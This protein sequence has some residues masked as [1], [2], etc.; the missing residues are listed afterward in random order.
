MSSQREETKT[1]PSAEGPNEV[2]ASGEDKTTGTPKKKSVAWE[3]ELVKKLDVTWGDA[4]SILQIARDE[5]GINQQADPEESKEEI[6]AKCEEVA[7]SF[8]KTPRVSL[9]MQP[10]RSNEKQAETWEVEI[11]DKYKCSLIDA[12]SMLQMAKHELEIEEKAYPEEKKAVVFEKVKD[13]SAGFDF[14]PIF[15]STPGKAAYSKDSWVDELSADIH[16]NISYAKQL[17]VLAKRDLGIPQDAAPE[18]RKKEVFDKARQIGGVESQYKQASA[19]EKF[20]AAVTGTNSIVKDP[21]ANEL[22]ADIHCNISYAKQLLVLAKRDLGIPQD[23]APESRK[24]EVFDKARQIGGVE[25]QY[26]QASAFE[27]FKAAVT[28]TNSIVKDPWANELSA[29]IHCNISYAKQLLVL[30][31]RDLGIPQ[32]KSPE[33]KKKEVFDKARQI[34]GVESQYKSSSLNKVK[35]AV[36]SATGMVVYIKDPWA[37]EL[38]EDLHCRITNA[39]HLLVLAKR[40]LGLPDD[41]V[42]ESKKEEIMERARQLG[43]IHEL[44]PKDK[45]S[46]TSGKNHVSI[47][48]ILLL[49]IALVLGL[50]IGLTRQ[51]DSG[52][53][54]T[55]PPTDA[56]TNASTPVNCEQEEKEFSV[57]GLVVAMAVNADISDVE[58]AY[59]ARVFQ[60]T[61]VAMLTGAVEDNADYCDP[62]CRSISNIEVVG[63]QVVPLEDSSI[64]EEGCDA[65]LDLIFGVNGTFVGCPDT[66]FP[67][68]FFTPRRQLLSIANQAALN[69]ASFLRGGSV[70]WLVDVE[71]LCGSC[72]DNSSSSIVNVV[73]TE[74]DMIEIINPLLSILP[75]VCAVTGIVTLVD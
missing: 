3:K 39:K 11:K 57:S 43:G 33:S 27:K 49:L 15:S 2:I 36:I 8:E 40:D 58:I 66:E 24:K 29:D 14:T 47:V 75:G 71:P 70:R 28:G 55:T 12:T 54:A 26:K 25:S 65:T 52:K 45:V 7:E 23:A 37:D 1:E 21:W 67:G 60:R 35:D 42:S 13:I 56:P 61:Y 64:V 44:T 46:E 30:A 38:S 4:K 63:N 41:E 72:P 48:V 69:T 6:F 18:S 74:D 9:T 32:D 34:G 50:S 51:K 73:P 68:L 62:F 19:F 10:L 53:P 16:C 20:K 22:S 5:L 17:L 31:K 59:A